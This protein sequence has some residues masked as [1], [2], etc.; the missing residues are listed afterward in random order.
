MMVFLANGDNY[1][2]ASMIS[3][4]AEDLNL[5][6]S[7]AS[8]SV[9]AYMLSFGL[10]TLIFGPLADRFGKVKVINI[11]AFGT[12]IFS[13]LGALA[14]N[15]PS[16]IF[17]RAVNGMFGA[18]IFPVTIAYVGELFDDKNRHMALAKVMGLGFLGTASATAIGGAVAYFGSWRYV[19]L[20]YGIGE[21]ILAIF[22][23][24]ML[25]RDEPV[26]KKF[27]LVAS[28][29]EALTNSKFMRVV[30][31]LFFVG[32]TVLG[33]FTFSGILIKEL[34]GLNIF[35]VGLI[36]S[37]FGIGTVI[38]SKAVVKV[39]HKLKHFFLIFAGLLG[40]A[41]LLTM[42]SFSH[43]VLIS[44]GFLGYGI[45]FI[46]IQS[47]II[48]AAQENLPKRKGTA[49]SMASFHI[50]VGAAVG[51]TINGKV[52]MIYGLRTI[53]TYSAILMLVA[54]IIAAFVLY[55]LE[56]K[57]ENAKKMETQK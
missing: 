29:K 20:I 40:A 4:I 18:G 28:Y 57:K 39:R 33:S 26:V 13:M 46:F 16:L 22:M 21:I 1:A 7:T 30:V 48:S 12:A 56:K 3:N 9:T 23:L 54:A 47:T 52:I 49:M 42:S 6:I 43:P 14:F 10:F 50:F 45:A 8:L 36:L 55:G 11:A 34:T 37:I 38:G 2:A 44:I 31:I 15:L 17:F 24:R 35:I 53:F 41:S 25:Q 5:T 19:Y 32:F 51:T 27:S